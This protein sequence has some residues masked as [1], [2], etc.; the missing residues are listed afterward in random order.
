MSSVLGGTSRGHRVNATAANKTCSPL[1]S[2]I[3][4]KIGK[5]A[6]FLSLLKCPRKRRTFSLARCNVMLAAL[7]YGRFKGIL[8]LERH[9]SWKQGALETL[10]HMFLH[11]PF[12]QS[13]RSKFVAP[14]LLK[15]EGKSD[16]DKVH[17]ML[18]VEVPD[19][20]ER[21]ADF[22]SSIVRK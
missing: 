11:C 9:C 14:V 20:L 6:A 19:I 22:I 15:L 5:P 4:F 17:F 1:F 10:A 12:H 21:I 13:D 18:S 8:N 16:V 7:L 2:N 3:P